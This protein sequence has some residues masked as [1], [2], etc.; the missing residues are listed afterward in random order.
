MALE[1]HDVVDFESD[2]IHLR[3]EFPE[4]R[5]TVDWADA[6][7]ITLRK[8]FD[9]IDLAAFA[10]RRILVCYLAWIQLSNVHLQINECYDF[11]LQS[12]C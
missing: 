7:S 6:K 12:K 5:S 8:Q 9:N 1:G 4:I 3:A 11:S 2:G 10:E